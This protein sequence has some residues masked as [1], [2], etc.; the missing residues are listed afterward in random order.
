MTL[1]PNVYPKGGHFFT[2]SDGTRIAGDTWAGVIERVR[3]YRVRRGLPEGNPTA[4]VITQACAR[5]PVIC[6]RDNPA[7]DHQVRRGNF[8]G[9]VLTWLMQAQSRQKKGELQFV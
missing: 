5:E 7:Y 3:R 1:N 9:R 6:V 4:E 8:K 2:E